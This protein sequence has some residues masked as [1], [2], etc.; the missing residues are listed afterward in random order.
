LPCVGWHAPP[1]FAVIR[2][3]MSVALPGFVFGYCA[4]L[5]LVGKYAPV[6]SKRWPSTEN[7]CS[8]ALGLFGTFFM[9]I[10]NSSV[11]VGFTFLSHPN[12]EVSLL[13]YP[14][15]TN[16]ADEFKQIQTLC[17]IG[18]ALWCV[19]GFSVILFL[20]ARLPRYGKSLNFRLSTASVT[21]RF[22]ST[23]PWWFVF[24]LV[25]NLILSLTATFFE[26]PYYQMFFMT[27]VLIAY[28]NI[29]I[30][31]RPYVSDMAFL[32]E[33]VATLAK[34]LMVIGG[35]LFE[36][37]RQGA[38]FILGVVVIAYISVFILIISTILE[39][40]RFQT[41]SREDGIEH[42]TSTRD[43]SR[44]AKVYAIPLSFLPVTF[45]F[46]RLLEDERQLASQEKARDVQPINIEDVEPTRVDELLQAVSELHPS[47]VDLARCDDDAPTLLTSRANDYCLPALAPEYCFVVP[48]VPEELLQKPRRVE[49]RDM[50]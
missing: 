29:L 8:M 13:K 1:Q 42:N 33:Y 35:F 2:Q 18:L 36:A 5:A 31:M 25:V 34:L 10:A 43:A 47:D 49:G 30:L 3:A 41:M 4:F 39:F 16:T 9:M 45:P 15:L 19:L 24:L 27:M 46:V 28:G 44:L 32:V 22:Q 7:A 26:Q 40:H 14:F 6:G 12:G 20:F 11:A 38:G 37:T 50:V 23:T 48:D 21:I 17:I